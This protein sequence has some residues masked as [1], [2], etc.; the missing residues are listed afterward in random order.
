[1]KHVIAAS[2]FGTLLVSVN[3]C[4]AD[5]PAATVTQALDKSTH[6][7]TATGAGKSVVA[8]TV[9]HNGEFLKTGKT[10]LAEMVL[11]NKTVTRVGP[12]TVLNYSV[13]THEA[14]LQSGTMLFSKPKD[15]RMMILNMSSVKAAVTG[16]TGFVERDRGNVM[17]G[18]IEGTV[19]V[20]VGGATTILQAGK[21]LV[22]A[23]TKAQVVSFDVPSFISTSAFFNRFQRALP[24]ERAVENEVAEYNNMVSR[25]FITPAQV[26]LASSGDR[27]ESN[28]SRNGERETAGGSANASVASSA[29]A[30]SSTGFNISTSSSTSSSVSVNGIAAS[31]ASLSREGVGTI[32]LGGNSSYTGGI[33][34]NG[35]TLA[36]GG[37]T[38][39]PGASG[40]ALGGSISG[41]ISGLPSGYHGGTGL[42]T[43]TGATL[44]PGGGTLTLS[45]GT[46]NPSGGIG[47]Q[48]GT[49][50][51][52]TGSPITI[53]GVTIPPHGTATIP[54]H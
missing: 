10:S 13:A 23:G 53:G 48:G 27:H 50:I 40:I 35:G 5:V 46:L 54:G 51:N 28:V 7:M 2:L 31:G 33:T 14:D 43:I 38:V 32:T 49:I 21:M 25:G 11:E 39:A 29:G 3:H 20:T 9:L 12:N 30:S 52:N 15:G 24:N 18:V 22:A 16:T 41:T 4:F 8:G 1:M 36:L 42:T 19:H 34:V 6:S 17:L 47:S 44:S 37:A 45:G 26:T